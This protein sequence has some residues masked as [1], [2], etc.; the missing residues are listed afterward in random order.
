M[1]NYYYKLNDMKIQY[2]VFGSVLLLSIF[3]TT[4]FSPPG[5]SSSDAYDSGYDHGCDD[6]GISDPNNRY[7]NQP[8]KGPAFHTD[9]F[10]EGYHEGFNDCPSTDTESTEIPSSNI[11]EPIEANGAE[12]PTVNLSNY[13]W[14]FYGIVFITD[15]VLIGLRWK[16]RNTRS[17]AKVSLLLL[18][19][20][21]GITYFGLTSKDYNNNERSILLLF[22]LLILIAL[23]V[24]LVLRRR[25]IRE[26]FSSETKKEAL[27]EQDYKCAI[28][29]K[30]MNQWD[31]DF[32]HKNGNRSDNRLSNCRAL[33][34]R[35]HRR[36]HALG[37]GE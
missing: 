31:R 23:V 37:E 6:A 3:S 26:D 2:I 21:I 17:R 33:H 11:D 13:F 15:V 34:P 35:C 28:C 24:I 27:S 12:V 19:F 7:I 16:R 5:Y 36:M 8:D 18:L 30:F 22:G 9:D 1:D 32:D 29:G 10:M 4:T 14:G 25:K 20:S